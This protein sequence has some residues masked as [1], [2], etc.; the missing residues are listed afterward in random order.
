MVCTTPLCG[1]GAAREDG[2]DRAD[3]VL[4]KVYGFAEFRGVQRAAIRAAIAGKDTLILMATGGGKSLCYCVPP[5]MTNTLALVISPLISLMQD[6]V[7]SLQ[8][9]GVRAEYLGSAQT[10]KT[11]FPRALQREFQILY[12]TPERAV[13][14]DLEVAAKLNVG[15]IAIDEAHCTSEWGHDFRSDYLKLG[16]LRNTFPGVPIMALTATATLSTQREIMQQLRMC[17][18]E[19][20]KTTFDR[21]N[22]VYS[23]RDKPS[24]IEAG[25]LPLL[26]PAQSTIIYVPTTA[27]VDS[28]VRKLLARGILAVAYHSKLEHAER[29]KSHTLFIHDHATVMVATLGY[30]MG[31]DKPDVRLVI[32]WGPPKSTEAY[33]QQSG[34]AGRDGQLSECV[35]FT[36]RADWTKLAMMAG[37]GPESAVAL[38]GLSAMRRYAE[39]QHVCRRWSLVAHFGEETAW[40]RCKMCDVCQNQRN[41]QSLLTNEST[42]ACTVLSAF[43]DAGGYFG[44]LTPLQMLCGKVKSSHGWLADKPSFA[45]A[46]ASSLAFYRGIAEQLLVKGYLSESR[47]EAGGRSYMAIALS[48]T[49]QT[50]LDTPR[51]EMML[52]TVPAAARLATAPAAALTPPPDG[53]MAALK[54]VRQQLAGDKPAFTVASNATLMHIANDR[55]AN[56]SELLLVPGIG[57]HKA[58]RFGTQ[59]L[60]CV[61]TH[62]AAGSVCMRDSPSPPIGPTH[63][64]LLRARRKI[65]ARRRVAPYMLLTEPVIL[66]L[67]GKPLDDF[68]AFSV[69]VPSFLAQ[70]LWDELTD[71]D[72]G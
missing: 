72:S 57:T 39:T 58:S 65:A 30:G 1:G 15:L 27:E 32:H 46:P 3:A 69:I 43:R 48:T 47:R 52:H 22:L 67:V 20:L 23:V 49:G 14:F 68:E 41:A 42:A 31:I 11:V 61:A 4:Q 2:D 60:A 17:A 13:S 71:P 38:A 19:I 54:T 64:S 37:T 63:D 62:V 12:C 50:F 26:R 40:S 55:P 18:P 51:A 70:E 59:L 34:R 66:A 25:L 45:M 53:L 56:Q 16:N 10:D 36:A 44:L 21:P 28:I 5:L 9:K 29:A 6:Q 24:Q 35:L 7:L 33:Y 8:A